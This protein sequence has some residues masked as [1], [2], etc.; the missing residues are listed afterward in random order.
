MSTTDT[1]QNRSYAIINGV[2]SVAALALLSWILILRSPQNDSKA[3]AFMPAVNAIFNSLSATFVVLGLFA[4][5]AKKVERHKKMMLSALASSALFLVG[6]L[7]YH[8]VHGDTP[9]PKDNGLR[10]P[11]LLLLASHIILSIIALPM[12]LWTFS[13]ALRGQYQQHRKF[14]KWT[15]P[16][17][18]YVSVTGVMVFLMLR[19]AVG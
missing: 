16:L 14:A 8:Y 3:L 19:T 15:Y 5:R 18:L 17:W 7:V 4:I 6:Y 2:V 11:Y 10:T 12:I 13:L 1:A 9:F